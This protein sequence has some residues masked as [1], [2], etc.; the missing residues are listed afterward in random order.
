MWRFY[1]RHR[2]QP[3]RKYRAMRCNV[4]RPLFGP[5][6]RTGEAT[7]SSRARFAFSKQNIFGIFGPV[8]R[9]S[10]LTN[11]R[12]YG[13]HNFHI[14]QTHF[15]ITQPIKKNTVR[16]ELKLSLFVIDGLKI[17][18]NSCTTSKIP[19]ISECKASGLRERGAAIYS[20][21]SLIVIQWLGT[22][23]AP[24]PPLP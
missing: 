19:N 21:V 16:F 7:N 17:S 1:C 24:A 13:V 11:T 10:I 9:E 23:S 8:C 18:L 15:Q 4:A 2:P 20:L 14:F 3:T 22:P 5:F 12:N 6:H